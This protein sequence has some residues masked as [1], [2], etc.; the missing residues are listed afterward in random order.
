MHII[1][2]FLI[3]HGNNGLMGFYKGLG[4]FLEITWQPHH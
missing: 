4:L 1:T 2:T 3:F